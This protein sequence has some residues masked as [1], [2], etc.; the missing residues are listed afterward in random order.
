[1]AGEM[2]TGH[3]STNGAPFDSPGQRPGFGSSFHH[4]ALK[5]R[6]NG[7]AALSGLGLFLDMRP[8]ALPWAIVSCPVGA[9]D[10]SHAAKRT[11]LEKKVNQNL[12]GMGYGD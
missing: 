5:G 10:K 11:V 6:N 12:E 1:M 4:R 3:Y 9:E 2:N 7:C 8:R